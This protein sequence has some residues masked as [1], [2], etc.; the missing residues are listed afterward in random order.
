MRQASTFPGVL[1]ADFDEVDGDYFDEPDGSEEELYAV[2]AAYDP[3]TCD[4]KPDPDLEPCDAQ[5]R[6]LCVRCEVNAIEGY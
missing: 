4:E 1:S 5:G 3:T 2:A 6:R